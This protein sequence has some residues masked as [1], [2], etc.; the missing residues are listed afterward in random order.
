MKVCVEVDTRIEEIFVLIKT[1]GMSEE[2]RELVRKLETPK[3]CGCIDILR[4]LHRDFP[5]RM[6]DTILDT[7]K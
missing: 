7:A 6:D 4:N 5:Y 3:H 2:V 1:P